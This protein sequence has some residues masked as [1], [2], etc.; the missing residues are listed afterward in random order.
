MC[1]QGL[2]Q[3]FSRKKREE[4]KVFTKGTYFWSWLGPAHTWTYRDESFGHTLA[5]LAKRRGGKFSMAAV[6]KA[7]LLRFL[8]ANKVPRLDM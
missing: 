5:L 1:I 6:S 4:T 3:K 7:T 8:A 2:K